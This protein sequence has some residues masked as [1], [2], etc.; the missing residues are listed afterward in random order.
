[1]KKESRLKLLHLF[2]VSVSV[3]SALVFLG[4]DHKTNY[5]TRETPAYAN[6]KTYNFPTRNVSGFK[7]LITEDSM[8]KDSMPNAEGIGYEGA[9]HGW[10]GMKP[11]KFYKSVPNFAPCEFLIHENGQITETKTGKTTDTDK[12]MIENSEYCVDFGYS[13]G[14]HDKTNELAD[15]ELLKAINHYMR[16]F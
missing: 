8:P 9:P 2:V 7:A 10:N 15:T 11:A 16:I 3:I 14:R 4:C 5:T 13:I 12:Q 1:M 6:Y